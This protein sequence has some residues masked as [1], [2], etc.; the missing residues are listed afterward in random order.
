MRQTINKKT[1]SQ[2][3]VFAVAD[4]PRSISSRTDARSLPQIDGT[5]FL[6]SGLFH[7]IK[8]TNKSSVRKLRVFYLSL[9]GEKEK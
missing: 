9:F 2:E 1:Q 7:H 8:V 3:I 5:E 6:E 4:G